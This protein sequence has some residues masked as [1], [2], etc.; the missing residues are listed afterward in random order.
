MWL[1]RRR[2]A[3]GVGGY[4]LILFHEFIERDERVVNIYRKMDIVSFKFQDENIMI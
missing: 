1:G 4:G 3:R 2:S